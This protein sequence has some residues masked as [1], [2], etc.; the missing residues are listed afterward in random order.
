ML[1]DISILLI[2]FKIIFLF[3][4]PFSIPRDNLK[5][6]SPRYVF[7]KIILEMWHTQVAV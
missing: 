6:N 3:L 5:S 4:Q 7:A 1:H 2:K